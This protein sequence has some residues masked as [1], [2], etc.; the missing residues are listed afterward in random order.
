MAKYGKAL[1]KAGNTG[2]NYRTERTESRMGELLICNGMLAAMPYYIENVSLN[3]YSLEE[4][5]YYLQQNTYLLEPDFM[6]EEL[7]S[8][9]EQEAG[10]PALASRLRAFKNTGANLDAFVAAILEETGFCSREEQK[11]ILEELQ[12]TTEKTGYECQKLRADKW[13]QS[14]KYMQAIEEYQKILREQTNQMPADFVG[15]V[16]HNLGTAYTKLFFWQEAA[17]CYQ[18]AYEWNQ[19]QESLREWLL[20]YCCMQDTAGFLRIAKEYLLAEEEIDKLREDAKSAGDTE[21]MH[22]FEQV[23]KE[24]FYLKKSGQQLEFEQKFQQI[25]TGWKN[26]YRRIC[27][28]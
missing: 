25:V 22:E 13:M 4:L 15:N 27:R 28:K 7:C 17:A 16:W 19:N 2:W 20:T 3:I 5:C 18:K 23:V 12:E 21:G 26:D 1:K 24:L 14:Q 9:I 11:R 10:N 8:W 6:S